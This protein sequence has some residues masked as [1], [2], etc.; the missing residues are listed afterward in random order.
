MKP[1]EFRFLEP[2][3]VAKLKRKTVAT[4]GRAPRKNGVL[5]RRGGTTRR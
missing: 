1:G 5:A 2:E 4:A 3:E